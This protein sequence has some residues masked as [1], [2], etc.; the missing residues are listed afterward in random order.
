[1]VRGKADFRFVRFGFGKR[2]ERER[3]CCEERSVTTV[4]E[5]EK[6]ML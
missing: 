5:R 2:R 1:M 6:R 4:R 3:G